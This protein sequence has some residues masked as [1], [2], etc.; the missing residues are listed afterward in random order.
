[1]Q[2]NNVAKLQTCYALFF[3]ALSFRRFMR[4]DPVYIIGIE[5]PRPQSDSNKIKKMLRDRICVVHDLLLFRTNTRSARSVILLEH[6]SVK[7]PVPRRCAT[8][9]V[10][11]NVV[12]GHYTNI[13]RV[14][15][16]QVI[17]VQTILV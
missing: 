1:M 6:R 9:S 5:R 15:I 17:R 2:E 8:V 7:I 10:M 13:T 3:V 4:N 14:K 12:C 11:Q 16:T